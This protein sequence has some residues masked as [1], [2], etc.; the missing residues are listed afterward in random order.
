MSDI[1]MPEKPKFRSLAATRK[2]ELEYPYVLKGELEVDP[3]T[4]RMLFNDPETVVVGVGNLTLRKQMEYEAIYGEQI[5]TTVNKVM[6]TYYTIA[7]ISN[8]EIDN[9]ETPEL[10][11]DDYGHVLTP[12]GPMAGSLER[13][14][15][16]SC[17]FILSAYGRIVGVEPSGKYIYESISSEEIIDTVKGDSL[18]KPFEDNSVPF[19]EIYELAGIWSSEDVK[20]KLQEEGALSEAEDDELKN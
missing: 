10:R 1:K 4:K 3:V 11:V 5:E 16:E 12:M 9:R 13:N 18:L 7:K 6:Y 20:A 17:V 14:I 8:P 15:V 2:E 19:M